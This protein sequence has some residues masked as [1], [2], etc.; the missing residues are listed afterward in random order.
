MEINSDNPQ[1]RWI[2]L[3]V[4][5]FR[6]GGLIVYPTDSYYGLGCDI[7]KKKAIE[8]IYRLKKRDFQHPLSFIF[9]DLKNMS[10]YVHIDNRSYKILKRCLPGPYTFILEATR[11]IPNIMQTKRRT[12]GIRIPD[13]SIVQALVQSLNNPIINSSVGSDSDVMMNDPEFIEEEL[14]HA[15]D[16]ILD[17]GIIISEPSTVFD[18]TGDEPELIREGK[19]DPSLVY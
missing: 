18:L 14:G 9:P 11:E 3:A 1:I 2:K 17:G 12:V 8:R 10:H 7:F 16:L 6:E 13:N 5:L 4:A 19:G 15:V